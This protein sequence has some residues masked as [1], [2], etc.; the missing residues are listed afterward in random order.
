LETH[1]KKT[2]LE[3]LLS[4]FTEVRPGEGPKV[5]LLALNIFLILSAYYFIKPVRE[6]LILAGGG[7]EVKSYSS[8]GQSILLLFVIPAY[9]W[10]A[11]RLPRRQL[12][13][14]VTIF[15]IS[16]LG[17]FYLLAQ[18]DV[19]LGVVFYLWVGIFNV[20]IVAQF[21]SF[22]NDV[23]TKE[24]GER[25]FPLVVFGMS[26]GAVLG[27][28][29]AGKL[30]GLLGVYQMLL[31]SAGVLALSLVITNYV[32]S[33]E[34]KRLRPSATVM[35]KPVESE[36]EKPLEKGGAYKL[37][38]GNR[39]L[40][41]IAVMILLLNWVNTNGEYILGRTVEHTAETNIGATT[42]ETEARQEFIGR[43]YSD[44]FFYVNL[45]GFLIQLFLVSR[46]IKYLGVRAALLIHPLIS[47]GV[48]GLLVFYPMLSVVR[49]AKTA[50]NATDYSLTNTL[51]NV[52]FLPT[53]REQK[54]KAKQAID[55]LFHRAGDVLS[56]LLVLVGSTWLMLRTSQFA[57]VNVV[58]VVIWM[59]VAYL[60]GREYKRLTA[61]KDEEAEE[62]G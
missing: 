54:Y 21:W 35:D 32:D 43:F 62:K 56:A 25:L 5:L 27:S 38:F 14:N 20:S 44:F 15:F 23:Y 36:A 8:A 7:A 19:P 31:L 57:L 33:R 46:L 53:T 42:A 18:V 9:A 26:A 10:M 45:L 47:L 13:N 37:V 24:E 34:R 22:A 6:A 55:T 28:F 51:R 48:Y 16:C 61:G 52:L 49:W 17:L 60:I 50:E 40:L 2:V 3:R 29:L 39:Y 58:L 11:G 1:L 12:I 4:L 30:I 59:A 41:L